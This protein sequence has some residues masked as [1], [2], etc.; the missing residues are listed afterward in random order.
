M[1]TSDLEHMFHVVDNSGCCVLKYNNIID[2]ITCL[3]VCQ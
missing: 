3:N 1:L 2:C